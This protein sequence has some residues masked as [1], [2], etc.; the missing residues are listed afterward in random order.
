M[1]PSYILFVPFLFSLLIT[2]SP[3][4]ATD[5]VTAARP[6]VGDDKLLSGNG[7]FALGF[8]HM[9]GGNGSTAPKWYLGVWFNTVSKFTPAWVANRENPLADGGASWQFAISGDGNLVISNRANNSMTSWS[10]QAN[11]TTTTS[12]TMAV[13]Q[14]SGNLVLSDAS[15]SSLIFWESFSHMTDTFL[16]GAKMGW[17]KATG[18]THGLV[19]SKNSGDL[20]PGVYSATPSSD[21]ANPGLSLVWNSSVVYWS[22]GPWNGD[23]FSNTP[24]LTAR[25]L[26]TFDFVSN[27]HEEYFTYRLRNDTMITRYVLDASGQAKNMIWSSVTEDWVTFYAKPGAQ[28]DVYAVCGAFTV[29]REDTLP[30]CNCMKGFSIRY[31]RDWELGDKTGGCLRNIPLNCG[32]TDRF[33]AMSNVRFPSNAKNMET[34][35]AD[36]CKLACLNDCSCTAYSYNGSCNIWSDGL[37]N[38]ARKYNQSSTGGILYLRLAAEDDVSESSMHTRG[39]IIGVVV[40]ASVLTLSLFT[41]VIMFVRRNKRNCSSVK[42]GRIKCGTVAFRYKDLQHATKN[43]SERLGG[44]S[45]GSVFKGVLTDSTVIAVKRLD[46]SRQGEKEFRAE[47]RSIGTIQHI[48]LVWLIG[49]CCEGSK[50]LL[51]YEYMPNGSLDSHLFGSKVT[52]VGWSTR[53]KIALGV[54]KGL[55]YMHGNCQDCIIHCDIKPQN[56]LLDASFVPKIADFGLS[57]FMG[58]D[59]SQVLTTVRGTIGY[60]APEWISGM[61]ISSKVDVYSYG[62]VL[63]EIIFGRRNFRGEC[64]SNA[65]YFPVQVVGKLLQGNVQCLLDQN[66]QGDINSEEVERACRVACWCIQDDELNRPTMAQVVQ[67]LEG[68]LEVDMPPMPKLLQAISGDMDSTRT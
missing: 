12:N 59:F 11:T 39:L 48:N 62:M 50:R 40:V 45:F 36:E 3:S 25:A 32:V 61:A 51:V 21:F 52:S 20:S 10:S 7:K 38:V 19:S 67:I 9:A 35:T 5:T 37:F 16:P 26:F 28:C 2:T 1:A 49:F 58:R 18:F 29:C 66:I 43:F 65:T 17:N 31:P 44:G 24:E 14:N 33:Y 42:H 68:I 63:L 53:Y 22:T 8:F 4:V 15:N 55:A 47:V 34:G 56:I 60:L 41:I 27:D 13:L 54:A 64:T 30:F 57:K 6:L 23:Y 46:G